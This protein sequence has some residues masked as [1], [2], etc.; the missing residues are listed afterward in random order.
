MFIR[1]PISQ[2]KFLREPTVSKSSDSPV[3]AA[4]EE[5]SACRG[6]RVEAVC[7]DIG[8][9]LEPVIPELGILEEAEVRKEDEK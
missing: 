1:I 3:L 5:V 7:S 4:V 2:K 9:R 6:K 8:N